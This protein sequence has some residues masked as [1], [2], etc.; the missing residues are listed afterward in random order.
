MQ[1][2]FSKIKQ[3]L[4]KEKKKVEKLICKKCRISEFTHLLFFSFRSRQAL[5]YFSKKNM[6]IILKKRNIQQLGLRN[7]LMEEF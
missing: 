3:F 4:Q 5:N 7:K 1:G 2:N 6:G